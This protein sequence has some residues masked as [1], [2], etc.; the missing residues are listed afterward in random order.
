MK[1]YILLSLLFTNSFGFSPSNVFKSNFKDTKIKLYKPTF[2]SGENK[3]NLKNIVFYTGGN[4]IIPSEIYNNFLKTLASSY[5]NVY[6]VTNDKNI[7]EVLFDELE[8]LESETIIIGHSTGCVNAIQE[9]NSNKFVKKIILMDPVNNK[10]LFKI[11]PIPFVPTLNT[12]GFGNK[13]ENKD[14]E[15]KLK[16]VKDVLL[17]NAEKSYDWS[18]FPSFNMPFIPAFAMSQDKVENLNSELN[19]KVV[20]AKDYGHS[21]V[22]DSMYSDFMHKT[23]SKGNEQR[24]EENMYEYYVWLTEQINEFIEP[25]D[26]LALTE[27]SDIQVLSKLDIE[28]TDN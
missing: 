15:L 28:S 24:G 22:L 1:I 17:L 2:N 18:F 13:E 5:Y 27:V 23:I 14:L 8:D 3:E 20:K 7:N 6:V 10:D 4:S 26:E 11:N 25:K 12:F 9:S 21:D 19:V 16:Y